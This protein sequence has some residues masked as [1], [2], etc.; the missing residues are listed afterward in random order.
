MSSLQ[1]NIAK[2]GTEMVI[3][4]PKH[5]MPA[6]RAAAIGELA[7]SIDGVQEAHLP[8]AYIPGVTEKPA[9]VLFLVLKSK[10]LIPQ[11]MPQIQKGLGKIM[12]KGQHLDMLP[13]DPQS[14]M[15]ADIRGA[16]CK[17]GITRHVSRRT[18]KRP[19]WKFW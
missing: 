5:P 18:P 11:V 12:P 16:D 6:D 4:K 7:T 13:I 15:L 8:M 17:V 19:W 14:G 3:G 9:Q 1:Q 2:A 10:S